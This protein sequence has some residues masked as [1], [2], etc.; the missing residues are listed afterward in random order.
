MEA[1][2]AL[3][4]VLRAL[5]DHTMAYPYGDG[6]LVDLPF[7]YG[8]G[9]AVRVLVE[10]MGA[11]YRVSDRATAATLLL[12]A[13]VNIAEGRAAE[14]FAESMRAIGLNGLDSAPGEITTFGHGDDLGRLILDVAQ[15]SLRVDQLRWLAT[16]QPRVKFVDRVTERVRVWAGQGRTA[17]C[18]RT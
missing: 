17:R 10:P 12:M 2:T 6:L 13:G 8:D 11:G 1:K 9:D 14:A 3:G 5:N 16:R 7:A 4:A 18:P 15:A